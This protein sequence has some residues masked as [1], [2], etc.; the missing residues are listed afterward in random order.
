MSARI[1]AI[2]RLRV[3]GPLLAALFATAPFLVNAVILAVK[4]PVIVFDGDPALDEMGLIRA[5]HL[6]QLV[7]N[8]S[9]YGFSHPGPAWFY[10]L[11]AVYQP[12]GSQSWG[13]PVATLTL[14]AVMVL[15]IVVLAWRAGGAPVAIFTSVVLL[16]YTSI[17][18]PELFR[19]FWPPFA[20]I[21][22]MAVLLLAA[23]LGAAGS[24]PALA[25]SLVIGSYEAQ[26]HVGT[27]PTVAAIVITAF[28][29]RAAFGF[30]ERRSPESMRARRPRWALPATA[31]GVVVSVAMWIPPL[32][33]EARGR[34]G[35]LSVLWTFF[36]THGP[37]RQ[38]RDSVSALGQNLDVF[39]L[40][41]L[42]V[43]GGADTAIASNGHIFAALLF[44]VLCLLLIGAGTKA[45]NRFAQACGV[46]ITAALFSITIS[47]RDVLGPVYEYLLFWVTALP[48]V[49]LI[50]WSVLVAQW[51]PWER[52]GFGRPLWAAAPVVAAS[53]ILVIS[54]F[55]TTQI[56]GLAGDPINAPGTGPIGRA[57]VSALASR[58][59]QPVLLNLNTP[60]MWTLAAG[61][62]LQLVKSG[63][64][65]RVTRGWEFMFGSQARIRGD[66]L[67][68]VSF[69]RR[70]DAQ[71]FIEQNPSA[72]L[73]A[74]TDQ[75]AVFLTDRS[76]PS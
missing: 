29:L 32:I 71:S 33:D 9:R 34:P 62:G 22:P 4:R 49:M 51:R 17:I 52:V 39:E 44:G 53:A 61:V 36:T 20:V 19:N 70:S 6:E 55:E 1:A 42:H 16:A 64:P 54:V 8:Y 35:N 27:V 63:H 23:A 66:E 65:V 31:L 10:V 56:N 38:W 59:G 24:T 30:I 12:L 37:Q 60:D 47:I 18:G 45:G 14:Q 2:T 28:A 72:R 3:A 67:S 43:S 25:G 75:Y 48:L 57:T 46:L 58:S 13:A 40:S 26:T 73:V 41:R 74:E 68:E 7:G 50:A 21:L 11:D 5:S 69:V 15:L 76:G